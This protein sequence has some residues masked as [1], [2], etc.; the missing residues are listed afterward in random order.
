MI[1]IS[2][3]VIK[4]DEACTHLQ[5]MDCFELLDLIHIIHTETTPPFI[6]AAPILLLQYRC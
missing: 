6:V 2:D 5:I 4:G 3:H 1:T